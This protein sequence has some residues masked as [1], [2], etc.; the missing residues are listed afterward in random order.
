MRLFLTGLQTYLNNISLFAK[1]NICGKSFLF[2]RETR[3]LKA[4]RTNAA[5]RAAQG[6]PPGLDGGASI[7]AFPPWLL[8]SVRAGALRPC[9]TVTLV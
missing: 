3:E 5:H 1:I 6:P 8:R 4:P 9:S 7:T 2:S